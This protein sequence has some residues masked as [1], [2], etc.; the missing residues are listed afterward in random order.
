MVSERMSRDSLVIGGNLKMEIFPMVRF[1]WPKSVLDGGSRVLYRKIQ[2]RRRPLTTSRSGEVTRR[3]LI[4][5]HATRNRVRR[6]RR[7]QG[8]S[9]PGRITKAGP[10]DHSR[11]PN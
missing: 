9:C 6:T 4:R 2:H 5:V 10:E 3:E 11:H 7:Q 1:R 8:R